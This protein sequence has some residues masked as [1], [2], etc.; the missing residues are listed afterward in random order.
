[1]TAKRLTGTIGK[2]LDRTVARV[3]AYY[4]LL[5]AGTALVVRLVPGAGDLLRANLRGASSEQLDVGLGPSLGLDA[6]SPVFIATEGQTASAL[7]AMASACL[8]MLPVAWIYILTR[9]KKG[10]RQS[11]VQT[12]IILP[13]VVAGV[14]ILVKNSLALAFS[15]AGIVA[16]VSF[17]N[18]LRDTKDAVHIFLATGVGLAAGVQALG[19]AA[20]L[21][22]AFNAV[23]L[24]LWW[25]DFGHAPAHLEGPRAELRLRRALADANRTNAFVSRLDREI[26]RS[27]APEQ[28]EAL[29][30]RASR[31][32]QR[33]A[34]ELGEARKVNGQR[35]LRLEVASEVGPA[36]HAAEGVLQS[37]AKT[38]EYVG[39]TSRPE[40]GHVLEYNVRLRKK[41]PGERLLEVLRSDAAPFVARAELK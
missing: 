27:L 34:A 4:V 8:L 25:T 32:R 10:F 21:S 2:L 14:V 36:R 33:V 20:A 40:G 16:A 17:R 19:V 24:V 9:Q 31:R 18:T 15:L 35:H 39:A 28:L 38:W 7:L 26:L 1:M 29:A 22:I 23:I 5:F 12:L 6:G 41:M 11:V 30:D 37:L 3:A 13:I